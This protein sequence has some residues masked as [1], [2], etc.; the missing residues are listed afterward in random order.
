MVKASEKT[1]PKEACAVKEL[2]PG[3]AVSF[4]F[5]FMLF[6][7]EPV[8][9]YAA[10]KDDFWFDLGV[11]AAPTLEIFLMFFIGLASVH[12][13]L[14]F[15]FKKLGKP[16]VYKVITAV[17]FVI[18]AASY[19]QGNFLAG[20]LPALD[21]SAVDWSVYTTD[22]I[23]TL[24]VWAVLLALI[25]IALV[26]CD[27]NSVMRYV[28]LMSAVIL[29]MLTVSLVSVSVKN[30]AFRPKDAFVSSAIGLNG[31]SEDKNFFIFMVDSQSASE[32]SE[33]IADE[34]FDHAFDD[35]TYYP[36]T[37]STFAYTRD[38]LPFVLSGHMNMNEQEFGDY[39]SNALNDSILFKELESR[40]YDMY[41]YSNELSWYGE[42]SFTIKNADDCRNSKF[43]FGDYFAEEMRYVSFKYLPYIFK[44]VSDVE[45]MDFNRTVEMFD[46]RNDELYRNF[47]DASRVELS[48]GAQFRLIHA[49]GAHVPLDMDEDLNRIT[50]GTYLQ[51]TAA[52]AKLIRAFIEQL[53][54]AGV[55][56]NSAIII[57]GDHGYQPAGELPENYILTRFNPVLLVKGFDEHHDFAVSDKPVSF[58]DLPQAYIDLLDGR[59]SAELFPEAEY[60]RTRTV[61]WYE[62]YKE[63]HKEEYITDG[64][65]TEWEKFVSTGK[66]YDL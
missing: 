51:K 15:L 52:T 7:Y 8:V 17:L 57:L 18:F 24:A 1:S 29:V 53:K 63:E 27:L 34:E 58:L 33:V 39:T 66:T 43:R 12:S 11:I 62:I 26:N 23:I 56:D 46:W 3:W 47:R 22:N 28:S 20:H 10:N 16:A 2:L 54:Q 60:P 36:D 21:G 25:I 45:N 37:L 42:K 41:L 9:M 13:G 32:F 59:Q 30:R 65:A 35:F 5:C 38:S 44:K 19:V 6:I 40:G 4:A 64:K 14:F 55:Y 31:A 48:K 61:I 50:G 49:E